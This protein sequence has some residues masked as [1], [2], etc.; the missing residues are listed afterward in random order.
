MVEVAIVYTYNGLEKI[1][2]DKDENNTLEVSAI[3]KKPISEWF[4]PSNGRD[5]WKGLINE[6]CDK[7]ADEK[8]DIVWKFWGDEEI[9]K[10]FWEEIKKYGYVEIEESGNTELKTANLE[11]ARRYEHRRQERKAFEAYHRIAEKEQLPEAQFKVGK[12]YLEGQGTE[13]DEN[14]AFEY[15]EKA[16]KQGHVEAQFLVG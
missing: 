9:K 11:E 4:L 6:V 12:Y 16:A 2:I 1:I 5:G 3:K 13:K 10:K 8:I 15:L 14:T 7:V